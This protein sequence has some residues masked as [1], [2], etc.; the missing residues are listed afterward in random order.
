MLFRSFNAL[1]FG[2]QLQAL[3]KHAVGGLSRHHTALMC[4]LGVVVV[5]VAFQVCLHLF[6]RFIPSRS[7]LDT[8]VFIQ[9][10][11]VQPFNK[12]VALRPS[13][14]RGSVLYPF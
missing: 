13:Y 9:Q 4:P 11:A 12:A 2:Y 6:H 5:K 1:F 10:R 8:E 7:S 14:L 3:F